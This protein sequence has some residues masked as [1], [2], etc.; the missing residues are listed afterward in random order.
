MI[1]TLDSVVIAEEPK[2]LD[3][4]P[5]PAGLYT[6]KIVTV[7]DWKPNTV[8]SIVLKSTGETINDVVVYNANIKLEVLTGDHKGRLVFDRL[9]THPNIPWSVSGFLHALGIESMKLSELKS[10]EGSVIDAY[11]KIASYEKKITD[12]D[13]G[14]EQTETKTKNEVT[15]YKVSD[16]VDFEI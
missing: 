5:L 4:T 13:T 7:E 12:P 11:I 1:Q 8:K 3:T 15:R 2:I 9:T 10:V 16:H 14:L 6:L